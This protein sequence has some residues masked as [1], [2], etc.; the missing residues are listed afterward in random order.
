MA[1]GSRIKVTGAIPERVL[2]SLTYWLSLMDIGR[3]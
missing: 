1:Q 2:A 3:R